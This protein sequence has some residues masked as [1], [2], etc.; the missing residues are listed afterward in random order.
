MAPRLASW[1]NASEDIFVHAF[2]DSY[3]GDWAFTV[4]SMNLTDGTVDFSRGGFQEARGSSKGDLLYVENLLAE[5]DAPGEWFVDAEVQRLYYCVNG[6]SAPPSEG[7]VAGQL[8]NLLSMLGSPE[9]PVQDVALA[10]LTFEHSEPTF[11]MPFTVASGGDWSF[12]DGGA[13]RLQGTSNC[14]VSGSL[15]VNLGGS[16]VMISGYNRLATVEDS[17]FLWLGESAIVSA[18]L[19]GDSFDQSDGRGIAEGT[20]VQRNIGHELGLYVK[21]TGFLYMGMTANATVVEN[22]FFNAPRAGINVND[23]MGGGHDISRN[24]GFNLVRET[25]DHGVFNRSVLLLQGYCSAAAQ[26]HS[27]FP[28]PLSLFL[29]FSFSE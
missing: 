23:G 17:E 19:S 5:L 26:A 14:S 13:L 18:G 20:V 28:P 4:Q 10:G 27:S 12:Q 9:Q 22:V 1:V 25:T 16:G 2:H 29:P 6:S 8:M 24:A 7:W 3:W 11:M 21:Q 15:F